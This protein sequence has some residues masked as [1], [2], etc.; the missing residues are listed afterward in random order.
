M[1]KIILLFFALTTCFGIHAQEKSMS[2]SLD[3]AIKYALENSY[4]TKVARNDI[5]S[6]KEKVWE[7][8]AIGLPQINGK[9]DYQKLQ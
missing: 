9:V 8:T 4:N 6:A 2:L 7:T 1:K 5:K 3:E